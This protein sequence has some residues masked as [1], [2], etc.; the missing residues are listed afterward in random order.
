[1]NPYKKKNKEELK[2][3]NTKLV[4]NYPCGLG[5]EYVHSIPCLS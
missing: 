3:L 1:M 4:D 5:E 2:M